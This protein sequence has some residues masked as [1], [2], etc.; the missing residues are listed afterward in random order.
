MAEVGRRRVEPALSGDRRG[1]RA[2][3]R[4]AGD[5]ARAPRADDHALHDRRRPG[6]RGAARSRQAAP[7][8]P[9]PA[10]RG[11]PARPVAA[12][13]A[14][15]AAGRRRPRQPLR[16]GHLARPRRPRP[17]HRHPVFVSDHGS[18]A[19]ALGRRLGLHGLFDGFLEV[20][21]FA[22]ADRPPART[23]VIYGGV[24]TARHTPGPK[25]TTDPYALFVGRLLPHKGVDVL[26]DALP[27]GRRLVIAGR[28]DLE[29]HADYFALLRA[30]AAVGDRRVDFR[31]DVSD[32]ELVALYQGA[33]VA[34]LPSLEVDVYGHRHQV[35]EL[36]G[37]TL[38]EAMAC[39]TPGLATD[40]ASLPEVVTD[41]VTGS[42]V[43]PNDVEALRGALERWLGD[44]TQAA[45]A[46]A[47]ARAD[48]LQ[49]FTWD[50]VAQRCL[51]AY[52]ELARGQRKNRRRLSLQHP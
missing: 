41:G 21:K 35:P 30:K 46:G 29:R 27:E 6:A 43:A 31:L 17:P 37:L 40:I 1:R 25:D 49:R 11:R 2:L 16:R 48:V 12:A 13:L 28:P 4:R 51:S 34:A 8:P 15:R 10:P 36:L 18:N 39:G 50:H 9:R 52:A 19:V 32:A 3:R 33:T 45:A 38:I 47:R 20:S 22:T 26:I 7:L 42:L 44:P 23:R 14:R 5:G 24:D